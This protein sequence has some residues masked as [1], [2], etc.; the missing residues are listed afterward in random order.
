[1]AFGMV[2]KGTGGRH[3]LMGYDKLYQQK[4]SLLIWSFGVGV[5]DVSIGTGVAG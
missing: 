3:R 2:A 5:C 4:R 1:M